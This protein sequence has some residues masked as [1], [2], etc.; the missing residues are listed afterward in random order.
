MNMMYGTVKNK[1]DT[2]EQLRNLYIHNR[3][4]F[5]FDERMLKNHFISLEKEKDTDVK[6][7]DFIQANLSKNKLFLT[8]DHPTTY[9]FQEVSRQ[10]CETLDVEFTRIEKEENKTGLMDSVYSRGDHQYPI[11]RYAIQ[12]YGFNYMTQEHPDADLFYFRNLYDY[13]QRF[14]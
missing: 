10:I 7:A 3:I 6:I 2:L 13:Y 8:Q 5:G 4:D 1:I 12:H 14:Y 11:S 9:I